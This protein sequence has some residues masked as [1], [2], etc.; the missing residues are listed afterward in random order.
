MNTYLAKTDRQFKNTFTLDALQGRRGGDRIVAVDLDGSCCL[1]AP[2]D[3]D[4]ADVDVDV[5]AAL[6]PPP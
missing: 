6:I 1:A 4:D 5:D 2:D 3:D